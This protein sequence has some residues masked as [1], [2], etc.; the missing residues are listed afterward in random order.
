MNPGRGAG[1]RS[2][3]VLMV[4]NPSPCPC[5]T[6]WGDAGFG[7]LGSE[8]LAS[9][10]ECAGREEVLRQTFPVGF[11]GQREVDKLR[12]LPVNS[13]ELNIFYCFDG[14]APQGLRSRWSAAATGMLCV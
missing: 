8:G 10:T 13:Q 1:V 4:G 12:I 14:N 5:W 9:T 11:G 2:H 7:R 6:G 3:R